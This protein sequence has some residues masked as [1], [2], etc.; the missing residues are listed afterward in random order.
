MAKAEIVEADIPVNER[1]GLALFV[2]GTLMFGEIVEE[3]LG[4]RPDLTAAVAPGWRAARLP[5]LVYPGLVPAPGRRASGLV[6]SGLSAAEWAVLDDFEG[7]AYV[8]CPVEA[9]TLGAGDGLDGPNEGAGPG[10]GATPGALTY[11]WRA[12]GEVEAG[13][14]WDP[15][16]FASHWLRRYAD[17]LRPG[18]D[19]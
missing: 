19:V 12:V 3:L 8:L 7:D 17:R 18:T 4:R 5:G 15:D 1:A 14:D 6:L 10:R 9:H 16:W 13:D 11:A 2:Y